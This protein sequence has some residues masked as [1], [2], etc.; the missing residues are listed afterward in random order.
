MSM[1]SVFLALSLVAAFAAQ[2]QTEAAVGAGG[3]AGA[4][5]AGAG[6]AATGAIAGST[7]GFVAVGAVIVAAGS[8]TTSTTGTTK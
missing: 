7:L 3:A 1:K 5:A 2:A 6:A 4:G 8:K